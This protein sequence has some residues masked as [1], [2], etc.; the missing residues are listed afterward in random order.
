MT[1]RNEPTA[2]AEGTFLPVFVLGILI[3]IDASF[4]IKP[5]FGQMPQN[6]HLPG[7]DNPVA[8]ASALRTPGSTMSSN[9]GSRSMPGASA[10]M[11]TASSALATWTR[12]SRG[13]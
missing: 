4:R 7:F 8:H 12:H 5:R 11:A 6:E 13:Q 2:E 1:K 10:S 3:I 9:S